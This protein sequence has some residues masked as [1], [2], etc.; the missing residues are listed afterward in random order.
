MSALLAVNPTTA[1]ATLFVIEDNQRIIELESDPETYIDGGFIRIFAEDNL[2][3]PVGIAV[4]PYTGDVFVTQVGPSR[5]VQV[6]DRETGDFIE[7]FGETAGNLVLQRDVTFHPV[8]G[9][10]FVSD[11]GS[12]GGVV[13]FDGQ[14]GELL[15]VFGDTSVEG[16]LLT[17]ISFDPITQNL[18]ALDITNGIVKEFDGRSGALR[19]TLGDGL[20][21][22]PLD[23]ALLAPPSAA[24]IQ[25]GTVNQG[26]AVIVEQA[27]L[28]IL[29][30]SGQIARI[31]ETFGRTLDRGHCD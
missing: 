25:A 10:L 18:F 30:R 3:V 29:T 26:F 9:N 31:I 5:G 28:L 23:L 13:Q 19:Q 2:S 7:T 24:S 1:A 17:S 16:G 15:G 27:R 21:V 14:S 11:I 8:T 6:F 4:H 22:A 12:G 20:L